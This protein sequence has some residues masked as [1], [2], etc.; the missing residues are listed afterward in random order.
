MRDL[1]ELAKDWE[2]HED[3]KEFTEL[4]KTCGVGREVVEGGQEITQEDEMNDNGTFRA[5]SD[6]YTYEDIKKE[7]KLFFDE[8]IAAAKKHFTKEWTGAMMHFAVAGEK[9]TSVP[10]CKWLVN[11]T[12]NGY[13]SIDSEI[14]DTKIDLDAMIGF[15]SNLRNREAA[16]RGQRELETHWESFMAIAEG[17]DIWS[18][19]RIIGQQEYLVSHIL[20]LASSGHRAEGMVRECSLVSDTA[21]GEANRSHL[22]LQRSVLASKINDIAAKSREGRVLHANASTGSGIQGERVVRYRKKQF[23]NMGAWLRIRAKFE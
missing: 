16:V 14:H 10:F 21:R 8:A 15:F 12:T 7:V 3:Y 1:E 6:S 2:G 4:A 18:L 19:N 23:G 13:G 11:G 9:D 5:A 22:I 17:E 20:P